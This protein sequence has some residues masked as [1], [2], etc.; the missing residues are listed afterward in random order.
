MPS[1]TY[2]SYFKPDQIGKLYLANIDAAIAE[3][4]KAGWSPAASD[5]RST[6]KRALFVID[7]QVDFCHK[8]GSLSVPGA[9][10]DIKRLIDLIYRTGDKIT[11]IVPTVDTHFPFMIFFRTWWRDPSGQMPDPFTMITEDDVK[12][13]SWRA[14]VDPAWSHAYVS[15]LSQAGKQ[16]LMIWPFHCMDTTEGISLVPPLAEAICFHSAAR[17][18]QP[19]VVHKGHIPQTEFYS[20]LRPEV[21]V[22][23]VPGGTINT[24]I[25][26]VLATHDEIWVA[27]EAK[28]HCVL[29]GM[30]TL[31]D[32]FAPTQPEVLRRIKFLLDCTSSVVHPAVDFEAIAQA[33]LESMSKKWGIELVNST[34]L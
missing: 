29:N 26:D 24:P 31:V 7:N 20:P 23:Q 3:G 30:K 9:L 6:P 32:Y 11:T 16:V 22:P 34:D 2:P 19:I 17:H 1:V 5:S 13:G 27:G 10:E 25:L 21:D 4:E 33:E 14:I 8:E 28:S 18:T 12:K 15:K